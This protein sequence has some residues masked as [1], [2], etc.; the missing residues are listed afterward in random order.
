MNILYKNRIFS[1]DNVNYIDFDEDSINI[2]YKDDIE[3]INFEIEN[4]KEVEFVFDEIGRILDAIEI[5][6]IPEK[7]IR[8]KKEN[9]DPIGEQMK[10]VSK[11][12]KRFN[13]KVIKVINE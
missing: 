4:K 13:K 10:D 9:N 3:P 11:K 1:L 5:I 6:Y 8:I 12:L 2:I 7:R